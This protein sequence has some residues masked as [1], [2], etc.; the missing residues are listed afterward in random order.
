MFLEIKSHE[1]EIKSID[2][3]FRLC[4]WSNNGHV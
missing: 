2:M 1:A 3:Y 4:K